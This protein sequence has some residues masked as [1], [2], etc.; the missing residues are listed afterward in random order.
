MGLISGAVSTAA[1][2]GVVAKAEGFITK[3]GWQQGQE[4]SAAKQAQ[5][6]ANSI[7]SETNKMIS[8]V[9][10]SGQAVS[11]ATVS[12]IQ[13][14]V[15]EANQLGVTNKALSASIIVFK[16]LSVAALPVLI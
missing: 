1:T 8:D 10:S 2:S 6:K 14:K 5:Q 3:T 15:A 13:A 12:N 4:T 7:F 16:S 11:N 9:K